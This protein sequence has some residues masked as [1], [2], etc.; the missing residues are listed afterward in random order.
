MLQ[1]LAQKNELPPSMLHR[2]SGLD[3]EVSYRLLSPIEA[4]QEESFS[5]PLTIY[6]NW[7]VYQSII[8][9]CHDQHSPYVEHDGVGNLFTLDVVKSVPIDFRCTLLGQIHTG[10]YQF[11]ATGMLLTDLK[12][13]EPNNEA[14]YVAAYQAYKS[15]EA[16]FFSV[17]WAVDH[18][19]VISCSTVI[20]PLLDKNTGFVSRLFGCS[21]WT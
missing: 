7:L 10:P 17:N 9:V 21:D 18:N 13:K 2:L 8:P 5:L 6:E 4:S 11:D 19:V 16:C 15:R 1:A 20:L 3:C 14:C 12:K